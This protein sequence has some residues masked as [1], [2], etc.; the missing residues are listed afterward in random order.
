MAPLLDEIADPYLHAVSQ[1]AMA[2]TSGIVGDLGGALQGALA[3]LE[4]LR[5]QDEP[6]W[7]AM[8]AYTAGLMEMTAG[9]YDDALRHL[10][11]MRDLAERCDHPWLAAVSRVYL[12]MLAVAQ[13]RPEEACGC[14]TRG[15]S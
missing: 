4:Q 10:T 15:W 1:L 7:S 6:F 8:A 3:A 13:G 2:W 14:W 11:A 12:G 9:R 5:G